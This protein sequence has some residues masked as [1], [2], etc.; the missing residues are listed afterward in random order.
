MNNSKELSGDQCKKNCSV[1]K[2]KAAKSFKKT[3]QII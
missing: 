2:W 3:Q 1:K